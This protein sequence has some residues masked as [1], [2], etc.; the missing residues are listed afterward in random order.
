[1]RRPEAPPKSPKYGNVKVVV[2]GIKFD[3]QA[4]AWRYRT[5]MMRCTTGEI[6]DL[7]K[8]VVFELV[9]GVRLIGS[10]RR[11]PALRYIADFRYTVV[12]TGR[13]VVEDVK[14]FINQVYKIKRHLMKAIHGID[15]EEV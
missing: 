9:P 8:Q 1:M 11:T 10:A 14:G 12:A 2:D 6:T 5:L 15:I 3:S 13:V 4:E 7:E